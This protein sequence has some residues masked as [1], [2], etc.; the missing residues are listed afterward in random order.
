M[1]ID[2]G[3]IIAEEI[4]WI[5][6][7]E[8]TF[9]SYDNSFT[10]KIG[11]TESGEDIRIQL[12]LPEF[13]PI[14][15]PDVQVLAEI[16]HPNIN[17][18]K[19]LDLQ[20]L[21]EW[22]PIY[23]LKDVISAARRLFIRSRSSIKSISK[24]V[25]REDN[26]LEQEIIAI[27]KDIADYNQKITELKSQQLQKAGIQTGA[28]GALKIS[29]QL[30]AEC[31]L[32]ALNDLIELIIVKFEE[33]DIDQVDFFRLYRRYIKEQYIVTQEV[34]QLQRNDYAKAKK[35]PVTS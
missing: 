15:R 31:H 32:L 20:L 13:Y 12:T 30:D 33:A 17:P 29:K 10:G 5:Y 26:I 34:Q 16:Q 7:N 35:R 1:N 3:K 25:P 9:H 2:T 8:P 22:E 18:D 23:R 27:Q 6:R 4:D 21:D 19:T 14:I 28:V 11:R 24:S